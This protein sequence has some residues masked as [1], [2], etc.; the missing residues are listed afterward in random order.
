MNS[1]EFTLQDASS[2]PYAWMLEGVDLDEIDNVE[3]WV[4]DYAST[5]INATNYSDLSD[6]EVMAEWLE[7]GEL[8]QAMAYIE[9]QRN[10]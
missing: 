4:K 10:S 9:A 7:T 3:Q 8:E 1:T 2:K 5:A 6:D